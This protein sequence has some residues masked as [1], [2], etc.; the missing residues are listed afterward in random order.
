MSP[1][2]S[3][4]C[5][6]GEPNRPGNPGRLAGGYSGARAETREDPPTCH[7]RGIRHPK[8]MSPTLPQDQVAAPCPFVPSTLTWR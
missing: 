7:P 5:C 2:S 6:P 3:E 1:A 4:P 8:G